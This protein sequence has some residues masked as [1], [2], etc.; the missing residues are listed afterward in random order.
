M[1]GGEAEEEKKWGEELPDEEQKLK[2]DGSESVIIR[3]N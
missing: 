1:L 3:N 2:V